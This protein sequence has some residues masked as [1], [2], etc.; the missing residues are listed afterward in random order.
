MSEMAGTD[1]GTGAHVYFETAAVVTALLL[2]GKYFETRAKRRSSGAL[3]A[4]LELGAR[5]AAARVGRGDPGRRS[6]RS[7][8]GSWCGPARRSPPTAS[9]STGSSAV[10]VSMLTGESVPVEV[11]DGDAVFGAT[12]NASGRL[13]VE[14]TRVGQRDR[15]RPDRPARGRGAGLEGAGAAAR[16]PRL[17]DLR[18][19]RARDRARDARGVAAHRARRPTRRSPPR[20]R[21]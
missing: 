2:L 14:A 17:G 15:A 20:S 4:L 19:R 12:V 5:N 11:T 7:G 10:D 6:C 1:T 21:C 3:R 16:R 18:P 13:V 9:W 8:S